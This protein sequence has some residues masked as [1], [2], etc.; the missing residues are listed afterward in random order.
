MTKFRYM[1]TKYTKAKN[2][3]KISNDK[4]VWFCSVALKNPVLEMSQNTRICRK[5]ALLTQP[6]PRLWNRNRKLDGALL[7][8]LQNLLTLNPYH[9][10]EKQIRI[11]KMDWGYLFLGSRKLSFISSGKPFVHR[12]PQAISADQIEIWEQR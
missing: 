2:V 12:R 1:Y 4:I 8:I 3:R 7:I 11:R 6:R 9:T 5:M 10:Y